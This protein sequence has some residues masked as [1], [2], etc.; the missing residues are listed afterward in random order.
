MNSATAQQLTVLS[1][2]IKSVANIKGSVP[3]TV[4][5][6]FVSGYINTVARLSNISAGLIIEVKSSKIR[7]S[8]RIRKPAIIV[9]KRVKWV[10]AEMNRINL[11]IASRKD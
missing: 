11:I 5:K 7:L 6:V 1:G 8:T 4:I 10:I 2:I 3:T 9:I